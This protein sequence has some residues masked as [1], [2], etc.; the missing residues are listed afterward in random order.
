M[1]EKGVVLPGSWILSNAT[2][3]VWV[4]YVVF[5]YKAMENPQS[6]SSRNL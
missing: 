1:A 3:D 6:W 4:T 2:S 5:L